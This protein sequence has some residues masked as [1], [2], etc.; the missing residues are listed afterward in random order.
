METI[1]TVEQLVRALS[2]CVDCSNHVLDVMS[3]VKIP[4]TEFE[5]Y[6]SWDD[7]K[8][9][10]NVL[11]RN[12]NFEVLLICW[13]EGQSSPIHDFNAQEAWIHPI[14]GMLREERFK[15]NVD[16][17]RLEKV[18]NVLLGTDEF[19][20]MNQVGIHRYS[21][22]NK[23]R[24][25]SLNIYSKPVSEWHVYDEASSNSTMKETWENKNYQLL[26]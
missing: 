3:N 26:D 16:D 11:A 5:K 13:E 14:Q 25:V 1:K 15:I 2:S 4:R 10:R 23:A 8:Y 9:A 24:T 7:E 6:Y 17:D 21:N 12:E 20:Y 22:A 19:S 18:S